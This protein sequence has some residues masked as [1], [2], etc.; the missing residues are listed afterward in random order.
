ME[1]HG[2]HIIQACVFVKGLMRD[3][4]SWSFTKD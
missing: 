3:T 4:P 1:S 2:L